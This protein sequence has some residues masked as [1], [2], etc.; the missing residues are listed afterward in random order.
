MYCKGHLSPAAFVSGRK[1]VERYLLKLM[2]PNNLAGFSCVCVCLSVVEVVPDIS[3][4]KCQWGYYLPET[5]G[6]GHVEDLSAD[7]D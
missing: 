5:I 2:K 6:N 7:P 3:A 4:S 1:S